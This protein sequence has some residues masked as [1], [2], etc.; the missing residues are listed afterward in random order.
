MSGSQYLAKKSV[1][2]LQT[3][4]TDG[5]ALKRTWDPGGCWPWGSERL[6]ARGFLC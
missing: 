2:D 3:E 6:S 1:A 4:K 5:T